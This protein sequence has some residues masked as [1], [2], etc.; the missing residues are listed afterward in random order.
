MGA[1]CVHKFFL[2]NISIRKEPVVAPGQRKINRPDLW[3][4]VPTGTVICEL[5]ALTWSE[6]KGIP[7][8]EKPLRQ[9]RMPLLHPGSRSFHSFPSGR[10]PVVAQEQI[11]QLVSVQLADSAFNGQMELGVK[12]R[13]CTAD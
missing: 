7:H 5:R 13:Q 12:D 11:L 1:S 6:T 3:L 4:L 9:N 2:G 8:H 10:N